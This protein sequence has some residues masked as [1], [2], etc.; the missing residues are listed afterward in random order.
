MDLP[1][2]SATILFLPS[3]SDRNVIAAGSSAI[4]ILQKKFPFVPMEFETGTN[5]SKSSEHSAALKWKIL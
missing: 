4:V 1:E 5:Q 2:Q 3:E